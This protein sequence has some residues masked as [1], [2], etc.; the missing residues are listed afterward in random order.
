MSGIQELFIKQGRFESLDWLDKS[1]DYIKYLDKK[2]SDWLGVPKSIRKTAIKPSGTVSLLAGALPGIHHPES[3]SYYRLI[4]VSS[5]SQ[6]IEILKKANYR[7]EP[8]A[9]DAVNTSVVYFPIVHDEKLLS[10]KDI[11]IWRQ[12]KDVADVQRV[13]A[14]NMVSVTVTFGAHE[15]TQIPE[16]LSA[17]D[18][19]LKSVSLLPLNE[20][21]YIQAPYTNAPREEVI[22]YSKTLLP[23]DFSSLVGEGDNAEANKFCSNDS[24]EI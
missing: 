16:C 7:V 17:F 3:T 1:Y 20:H 6:L 19:E 18:T 11:S 13:F 14:D 5:D 21:G 12:F 9:T 8:S 2:Y 23:L 22:E 10:K 15:V 24:C 4:R